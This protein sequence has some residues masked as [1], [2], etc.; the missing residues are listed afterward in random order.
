MTRHFISIIR[1]SRLSLAA[2]ALAVW[3]VMVAAYSCTKTGGTGMAQD[4]TYFGR[5]PFV[6]KDNSTFS[7]YYSALQMTGWLDTLSTA[8]P[9]TIILPNNDTYL[10]GYNSISPAKGDLSSFILSINKSSLSS[11]VSYD[12]LRGK[13]A[14]RSLPLGDNQELPTVTGSKLYVSRYLSGG[15]TVTT[16]N[17]QKV[18]S[19]DNPA[20]NGSINVISSAIPNPMIYPSVLQIIQ[21]DTNFA[22]FAA[23]LQRT[24]LDTLLLNGKGPYTV[25]VPSNSSFSWTL[26]NGSQGYGLNPGMNLFSVDSILKADPVRLSSLVKYH[27][28]TGRYFINDFNRLQTTDSLSLTTLNGETVKYFAQTGG[29]SYFPIGTVQPEFYGNGNLSATDSY[30]QSAGVGYPSFCGTV[31][32]YLVNS[33]DRPAGNGVVHM[34]SNVLLP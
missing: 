29:Y 10:A 32:C 7:T 16:V 33:T 20:S 26:F 8:G 4:S 12:L 24:H 2:S 1:K 21:S 30:Y 5:L 9:Y 28:L 27:I 34:L 3:V 25:L 11:Y 15:D 31:S 18:I 22:F 6:I 14:L 19:F 23:A 13:W 17:G